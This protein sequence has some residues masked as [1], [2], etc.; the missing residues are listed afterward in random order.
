LIDR[1]VKS[2]SPA[3]RLLLYVHPASVPTMAQRSYRLELIA[4][5]FL[6]FLLAVADASII[7]VVVKNA[8]EARPG[9]SDTLLNYT[10]AIL[11]ASAAAA[12]VISFVWVRVSHGRDKVVFTVALQLVM[13][14]L[15]GAL[16]LTPISGPGLML[17]TGLVILVRICW[18]GFITIRSS[19]WRQNYSRATRASITGRL[20]MV[21]TLSVAV[22]GVL[23]GIAMD[24]V[25]DAFR[26]LLPAGCGFALVGILAWSRLRIRGHEALLNAERNG[27]ADDLPSLN[28]LSVLRSLRADPPYR[29]FMLFMFIL[30]LGDLM[31]EPLL[32]IIAKEHFGMHYL[33]GIVVTTSLPRALVPLSIPLWAR[34]LDR[35]H[36]AHF[37]AV[38]SWLFVLSTLLVI[39]A[40]LGRLEWLFYV[41]TAIRGAAFGG[42]QLAWNLGHLDFAPAH[43]ASQYMGVHVTLTGVRGLIAPFLAVGVYEAFRGA[44][45]GSEVWT[46]A[47]CAGLCA[48]GGTGFVVL[49]RAMKGTPTMRAAPEPAAPA[50]TAAPTGAA[51]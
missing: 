1:L 49:S 5:I 24:R 22:L 28:P 31:V 18:A 50:R 12:N 9:I 30:G 10:V 34:F 3:A 44:A 2:G 21:Q 19:I 20:A 32:P 15:V 27:A 4:A 38:H 26:F 46:F 8:F 43:K 42:G 17:L 45:P 29:R 13:I 41:A 47:L 40:A 11:T 35:V 25:E 23:L 48:A 51:P 39:P 14:T 7:S 16:A 37:R 36:V 6:P 33:A